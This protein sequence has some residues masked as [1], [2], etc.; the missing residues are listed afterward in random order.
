MSQAMDFV[1]YLSREIGAR[2][3]GTEEEE[4]AALYIADEFQ[5][6]T[7][8][9]ATIEEFTSS[10]NL[11]GGRAIL[12]MVTIVASVLA[13]L[14]NVLTGPMFVLALI[15][16]VIY[17]M[18]S[19]GKPVFSN[20]LARVPSQN[21][22]AK[23]QPAELPEA[24]KRPQ[25]KRKIVLVAHYDTGKVTP[26]IVDRVESMSLPLP[27]I[28]LWGMVAAAFFLL[29][30]IFL[31][32]TGGVGLIFINILTVIAI[33]IVALPIVKAV[34]YRS[35]AYNEGA[36]NNATG[37][38]ALLEVAKRI[39]LGSLSEADLIAEQEAMVHGAEAAIEQGLVPE[40][41]QLIYEVQPGFE[42]DEAEYSE[43]ERLLAAKA[44][45]AALTG[46][47]VEQR[48]YGNVSSERPAR[49]E[50]APAIATQVVEEA[51]Q[52]ADDVAT[53]YAEVAAASLAAVAAAEPEPEEEI[54]TGFENAP[55]WFVSAQRNAKRS[56]EPAQV[57]RS[58]YTEAIQAA[59]RGLAERDRA[60][61]E[62]E[63]L[64]REQLQRERDAATRAALA[65]MR[66][67]EQPVVQQQAEELE[68]VEEDQSWAYEEQFAV[69]PE[70]V[71]F[72][73][74]EIDVEPAVE[75]QPEIAFEPIAEPEPVAE[76][77]VDEQLE[78]Q[79]EAEFADEAFD[80]ELEEPGEFGDRVQEEVVDLGQTIAYTPEMIRE[81]IREEMAQQ[82]AVVASAALDQAA[83]MDEVIAEKQVAVQARAR[84][85]L[86]SLPSLDEP[87]KPAAPE[88]D[89]PSRSGLFRMLRTDVPSISGSIAPVQP[90]PEPAKATLESGAIPRI[91]L[92]EGEPEQIDYGM[93][94]PIT[95]EDEQE[96]TWEGGA[97]S[98]LRLG[99]VNT[100]SGEEETAD[101]PEELAEAIE[102]QQLNEEIEQIYHFRNPDFDTEVWFVAIG[103]DDEYHDGAKAFL[104]EHKADLRG[105]MVVE[106]ES[107]GVGELCVASEEGTFR[108]LQASSRIKRFT[109]GATEA[110]GLV[111]GQVKTQTDSIT[112]VLQSGGVQAMHIMG[113]ENGRPSLKGSADDIIENV[114]EMLLEENIDYIAE[115]L[116]QD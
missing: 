44:A 101:E 37:V 94:L 30:R 85:Q 20:R 47:P 73:V 48:V 45:I 95:D 8:F 23:Y 12:S 58:R 93:T 18:E 38:A 92:D 22:V 112:T 11:E 115:L 74:P 34:L 69:E 5:K 111:L 81:A 43:E 89:N 33:I 91:T 27:K 16:A 72:T 77:V 51:V 2:P 57:Q 55:S 106:L 113:V 109:R 105:A 28:C 42:E 83:E 107:L 54:S 96:R 86:A 80:V 17:V 25:R 104:A 13:M 31:G 66:G 19:Y 10:A 52:V 15:A 1:E 7:G 79:D 100:R 59:E 62:E 64:M 99:H 108:K 14:F 49:S 78:L 84:E 21:V 60:R 67:E 87:A 40:G 29:L 88:N 41:A 9:P 56:E 116:K 90:Q 82:Q 110:T 63:R 36:N 103:S 97:F 46:Q 70:P 26:K 3:A 114:D 71:A 24:G 32:G 50:E 76:E 4:Q 53:S 61:E 75:P 98:R 35:A 68:F 102:D 65:A 6:E 39:S